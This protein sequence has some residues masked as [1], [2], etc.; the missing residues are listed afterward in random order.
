M[1]Y[2]KKTTISGGGGW[3]GHYASPLVNLVFLKIE[4]QNFITWGYFDVFSLKMAL[5]FKLKASMV[6]L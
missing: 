6:S 3:V 2:F 5:V 4:R 1:G